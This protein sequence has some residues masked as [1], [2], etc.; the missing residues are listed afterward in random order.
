MSSSRIYSQSY[1]KRQRHTYPPSAPSLPVFGTVHGPTRGGRC[2]TVVNYTVRHRTAVSVS[3]LFFYSRPLPLQ[4]F[5]FL[6]FVLNVDAT[7]KNLPS[8]SATSGPRI[9]RFR[10][11]TC[12]TVVSDVNPFYDVRCKFLAG[13]TF[14][15]VK[16]PKPLWF[17]QAAVI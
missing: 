7:P 10:N 13:V 14:Y 16:W 4:F 6:F 8:T 17:R 2:A 3:F 5:F 1:E 11:L 15:A 9:D 12:A